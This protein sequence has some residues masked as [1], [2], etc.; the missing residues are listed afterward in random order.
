MYECIV[1]GKSICPHYEINGKICHFCKLPEV[2][3]SGVLPAKIDEIKKN[4]ERFK[5]THEMVYNYLLNID[6]QFKSYD[7]ETRQEHTKRL[8]DALK[9]NWP[10]KVK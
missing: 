6:H 4:P 10:D 5:V 3:L 9:E 8:W 7:E 2:Y 1:N